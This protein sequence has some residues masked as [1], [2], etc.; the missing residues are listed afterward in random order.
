MHIT[1]VLPAPALHAG[2]DPCDNEW[3]HVLC[4][5]NNTAIRAIVLYA[6]YDCTLTGQLPDSFSALVALDALYM[7]FDKP[8]VSGL[9][10]TLPASWSSLTNLNTLQISNNNNIT[11]ALPYAWS[12]MT[13]LR[14]LQ[15]S[16]NALAGPLPPAWSS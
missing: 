13:A 2:T 12:N 7:V 6:F 8:G 10:G 11:G 1:Q 5:S 15:L 9:S 3:L 4:N 16:G 14:R